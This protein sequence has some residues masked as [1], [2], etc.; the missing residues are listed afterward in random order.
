MER[1]IPFRYIIFCFCLFFIFSC[2]LFS[3]SRKDIAKEELK[4]GG[5]QYVT[6]DFGGFAEER[7]S[8]KLAVTV[9]D[10]PDQYDQGMFFQFFH[11][12]IG[13]TGV[14]FGFQT[15]IQTPKGFLGKGILFGVWNTKKKENVRIPKNSWI[16]AHRE[17]NDPDS[18]LVA[19]L[20]KYK[21]SK[22][23]SYEFSLHRTDFNYSA[24]WYSLF[25]RNLK[26]KD[27][28]GWVF[29]GSVKIPLHGKNT[30]SFANYGMSFTEI[31]RKKELNTK[32]PSFHFSIDKVILGSS[33]L[34][35]ATIDF[36]WNNPYIAFTDIYKEG[37]SVHF[38]MGMDVKKQSLRGDKIF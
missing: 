8:L 11:T 5:L 15:D 3:Q 34:L 26:D 12:K 33:E 31:S 9:H 1:K 27:R 29:L 6:W 10:E 22:G 19:I 20:K 37:S 28:G 17:G 14:Y 32:L 23:N 2:S 13:N 36:S 30:N 21:W 4:N 16:I 18:D 24:D 7:K 35:Q 38:L 25:V